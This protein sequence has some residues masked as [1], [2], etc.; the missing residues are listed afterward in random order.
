VIMQGQA[1]LRT[2]GA[3]SGAAPPP[4]GRALAHVSG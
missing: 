4:Y 3:G 1:Q 2:E